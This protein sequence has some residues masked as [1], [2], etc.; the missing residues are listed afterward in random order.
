MVRLILL[1]LIKFLLH[2]LLQLSLDILLLIIM[3]SLLRIMLVL[4]L[5]LSFILEIICYQTLWWRFFLVIMTLDLCIWGCEFLFHFLFHDVKRCNVFISA[6]SICRCWATPLF[7][8][9]ITLS[10]D[11][12]ICNFINL[13]VFLG[14]YCLVTLEIFKHV[15][16]F[17]N[18]LAVWMGPLIYFEG[19]YYKGL[20]F[21]FL[22]CFY[23][24]LIPFNICF[25]LLL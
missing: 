1:L 25:L 18:Y 15:H 3:K 2:R 8:R 19:F 24:P 14:L 17:A 10:I 23:Q 16:Y 9:P 12:I 11:L 5:S 13:T 22:I 20:K 4:V 21:I 7:R 6:A